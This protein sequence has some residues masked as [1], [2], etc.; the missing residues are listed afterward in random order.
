ML[1]IVKTGRILVKNL[2]LQESMT[3][4]AKANYY[5]MIN[6]QEVSPPNWRPHLPRHTPICRGNSFYICKLF[7]HSPPSFNVFYECHQS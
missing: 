2:L 7:S 4:F 3:T 6:L 5:P 1:V